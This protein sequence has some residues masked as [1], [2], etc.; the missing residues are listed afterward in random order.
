[1]KRIL[2]LCLLAGL[3]VAALAQHSHGYL[4]A[5]PGGATA[6]VLSS[7]R[8]TITTLQLGAGG[9][10]VLGKSIGIGAELGAL[11]PTEALEAVVGVFSL[12][13]YYHFFHH[14]SRADP[15]LTGGY[16]LAFRGETANL[17]NFGGG[18]NYWFISR[19]GLKVEIR[20]HIWTPPGTT[21][22]AWGV[23]FG[24]AFR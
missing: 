17:F 24:L 2:L 13:G 11:A 20:D 12:N 23:R 1:M 6:R 15:F 10:G 7:R 18:V 5:A 16:T 4:Y 22:H 9:E 8:E 3:P 14:G 19:L 21:V